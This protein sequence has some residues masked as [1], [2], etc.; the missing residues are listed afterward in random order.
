[1]HEQSINP[2]SIADEVRRCIA[3]FVGMPLDR[4]KAN[5][6]LFHDLGVDGDDAH[7]LMQ[8]FASRFQIDLS[9]FVFSDYFGPEHA[10]NPL[11][12]VKGMLGLGQPAI[13]KRLE[14]RD[15]VQAVIA[16]RFIPP[17]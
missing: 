3:D 6:S 2:T 14:T 8:E 17:G 10:S 9:H 13:D 4:V 15:L 5:A 11:A 12:L 1:M 7:E 16:G